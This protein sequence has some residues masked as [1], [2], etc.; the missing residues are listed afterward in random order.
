MVRIS[1]AYAA[2]AC[3][4]SHIFSV[5]SF[6]PL[7]MAPPTSRPFIAPSDETIPPMSPAAT[8]SLRPARVSLNSLRPSVAPFVSSAAFL[9]SLPKPS[10]LFA[11]PSALSSASLRYLAFSSRAS[12]ISISATFAR[13]SCRVKSSVR[14]SSA[15]T[16]PPCLTCASVESFTAFSSALTDSRCWSY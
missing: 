14:L 8:E 6:S 1:S 9:T 11:Q 2:P 3:A 12:F 10:M 7:T 15:S 5:T 4:T 13:L 16:L